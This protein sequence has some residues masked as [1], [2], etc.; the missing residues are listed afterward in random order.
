MLDPLAAPFIPTGHGDFS[1]RPLLIGLFPW[2]QPGV[3][4]GRTW[5]I[6]VTRDIAIKRWQRLA[7]SQPTERG[8]LFAD[9]R[10][11]RGST[12]RPSP[13]ILPSPASPQP[14]Q[15]ITPDSP[16]PPIIRYAHRTFDRKWILTDGR[17]FHTPSQPLWAAHSEKQIYL[18]SWLTGVLRKGPAAVVCALIPDLD[19]FRGSF[20]SKNVV[21]LW[22]DASETQANITTGLLDYLSQ[23]YG[24]SVLPKDFFAYCYAILGGPEYT[25]CFVEELITSSPRIPITIDL[26]LF[27]QGVELGRQ[28]IW[29]H[30][31]G[32]VSSPR[33]SD[34]TRYWLAVRVPSGRSLVVRMVTQMTSVGM[35]QPK[36]S[37]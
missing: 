8:K 4:V 36:H 10:F 29:L 35:S 7:S 25:R 12:T 15:D 19:S 17:L 28:L 1:S 11:G 2:Q 5:P 9:R 34:L 6:A 26:G 13:D 14:V 24:E 31:Y 18:I 3:K 16:M 20:G 23:V 37:M 21:P 22:R 27:H 30:T 33:D 32:H